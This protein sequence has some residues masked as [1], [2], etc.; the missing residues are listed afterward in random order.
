MGASE[1]KKS[2]NGAADSKRVFGGRERNGK[3]NVKS[4]A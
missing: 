1:W 2:K 3:K 4:E